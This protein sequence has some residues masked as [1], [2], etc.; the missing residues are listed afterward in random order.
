MADCELAEVT[1]RCNFLVWICAISRVQS[2]FRRRRGGPAVHSGLQHKFGELGHRPLGGFDLRRWHPSLLSK[3]AD[4][5][6]ACPILSLHPFAL[7][8]YRCLI[9]FHWGEY[10]GKLT[11]KHLGPG[12]AAVLTLQPGGKPPALSAFIQSKN[13]RW[14]IPSVVS[15]K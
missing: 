1:T 5:S 14:L 12:F 6:A 7:S 11:L 9:R 15:H 3:S 8:D 4:Q 10:Y 2:L 13:R